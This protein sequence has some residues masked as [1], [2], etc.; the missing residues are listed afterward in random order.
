MDTAWSKS[1]NHIPFSYFWTVNDLR[2]FCNT[3][4]KPGQ[5][6]VIFTIHTRHFSRFSTDKGCTSL[7]TTFSNT[8]NDLLQFSRFIFTSCDIVEEVKG[9]RTCSYDI[10]NTHSNTVLTDRIVF[11]ELNSQ[12]Q[13]STDTICTWDQNGLFDTCFW[14]VKHATKTTKSSHDTSTF[15]TGHMFFDPFNNFITCFNIHTRLSVCILICHFLI[16]FFFW[17]RVRR[18]FR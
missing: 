16:L 10:V 3:D 9:L 18:I 6:I 13:L 11:V 12:H 1:K 15:R 17:E 8:S 5:I 2:F 4:S 7:H 14:K